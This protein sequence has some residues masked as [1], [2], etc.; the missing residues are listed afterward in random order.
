MVTEQSD[1]AAGQGGF[2]IDVTGTTQLKGSLSDSTASADK[3]SRST[4]K[5]ITEDIANHG[6]VSCI[7]KG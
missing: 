3:N 7:G 4:G 1:I 2:E 5:L 6:K